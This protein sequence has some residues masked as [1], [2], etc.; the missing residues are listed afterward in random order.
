[1][2]RE[3]P[4]E[5]A[6]REA[7]AVGLVDKVRWYLATDEVNVN[8]KNPVNGWTPL[9]WGAQRGHAE[10]VELL[11]SHGADETIANKKG[12]TAADLARKDE[13]RRLFKRSVAA[14]PPAKKEDPL[15]F[16]PAY[17]AAPPTDLLFSLPITEQP[18]SVV[19]E[20][21][22]QFSSRT[23]EDVQQPPSTIHGKSGMLLSNT[24]REVPLPAAPQETSTPLRANINVSVPK[25]ELLVY[26]TK[27]CDSHLL[28]AVFVPEGSTISQ[29]LTQIADELDGVPISFNVERHTGVHAIP[30]NGKQYNQS[31]WM[32]WNGTDHA[33]ILSRRN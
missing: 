15:P 4:R 21:Y 3:D 28:G 27:R 13:V 26:D 18:G 12:E 2:N 23:T 29:T 19:P 24:T 8:A 5:E 9:H 31:T 17:L 1:M 10:V 22:E 32:H 25:K 33:I 14:Q 6:L 16:L 11:L 7:A 20:K 30:V